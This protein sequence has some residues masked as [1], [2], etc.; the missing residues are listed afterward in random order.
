M[1][2]ML[3]MDML[4]PP[5]TSPPTLLPAALAEMT[6]EECEEGMPL[7]PMLPPAP[8]GAMGPLLV[9]LLNCLTAFMAACRS[10][11]LEPRLALPC[12]PKLPMLAE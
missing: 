12:R 3:D 4:G 1:C 11:T 2:A 10:S 6:L 8:P 9:E 7:P 5:E